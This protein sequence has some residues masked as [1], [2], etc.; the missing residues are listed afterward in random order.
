M[1]GGRSEDP[2][3]DLH[4]HGDQQAD[5][6]KAHHAT[7]GLADAVA[8][9]PAHHRCGH[10]GDAGGEGRRADG[11][12]AGRADRHRDD[13]A[14]GE[15]RQQAVEREDRQRRGVVALHGRVLGDKE[16]D[17]VADQGHP[18]DG[19][20]QGWVAGHQGQA[21]RDTAG[22]QHHAT[23][24]V[25]QGLVD[26]IGAHQSAALGLADRLLEIAAGRHGSP[27]NGLLPSWQRFLDSAWGVS[28]DLPMNDLAGPVG[29]GF[30]RV[31]H[32]PGPAV[33]PGDGG[34]HRRP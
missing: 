31:G 33:A 3:H 25:G 30:H 10:E 13:A 27:G 23:T 14:E 34:P 20:E 5:D 19:H 1:E 22:G 18:E 21:A 2:A 11:A 9:A 12:D 16:E 6:A 29:H 15:A 26:H 4:H 8:H 17:E 28:A 24:H 32:R 7:E